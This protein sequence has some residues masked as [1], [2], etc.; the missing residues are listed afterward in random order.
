[1]ILN[2]EEQEMWDVKK[3]VLSIDEEYLKSIK[4]MLLIAI[5]LNMKVKEIRIRSY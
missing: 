2:T 5:I 3:N 1:M 4:N